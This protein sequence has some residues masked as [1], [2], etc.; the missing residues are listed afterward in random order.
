[1]SSAALRAIA[2]VE[3]DV[4]IACRGQDGASRRS[5]DEDD[6]RNS[7]ER[8]EEAN[9]RDETDHGLER[10]FIRQL[11]ED[12]S[13]GILHRRNLA[14]PEDNEKQDEDRAGLE[15]RFIRGLLEKYPLKP[16]YT[17]LSSRTYASTEDGDIRDGEDQAELQRRL[18]E[19]VLLDF[20]SSKAG[21]SITLRR[22]L[23]M[24]ED[25]DDQ[26]GGN[27]AHFQRR[28]F[29]SILAGYPTKSG[30]SLRHSLLS[31]RSDAD[32]LGQ[33]KDEDF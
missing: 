14:Q 32:L 17:L 15:R 18:L 28:L 2:C 7:D 9:E 26:D 5:E 19:D 11:L 24:P 4:D 25:D 12:A 16:G 29:K 13:R 3:S 21:P 22:D 1:M 8:V 31:G 33:R 30:H 10:R 27:G 6:V 20:S 23:D